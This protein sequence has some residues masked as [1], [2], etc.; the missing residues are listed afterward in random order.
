MRFFLLERIYTSKPLS[1]LFFQYVKTISQMDIFLVFLGLM[2]G[3]LGTMIGA[4]GGF[5]LVPVLLL[6]SPE[7]PPAIVTSISLA[8]VATNASVGSIAYINSKRIDYKSAFLFSLATIP[9]SI[10]GVLVTHIIPKEQF[11]LLFG[12]ILILLS[13]FLFMRGGRKKHSQ[14][15][16]PSKQKNKIFAD[17]TDKDGNQYQFSYNL[18]LGMGLSV[19]IGFIAPILGIGGGIIHV[20]AMIEWL[21]FPV[22]IATATS[23]FILAIMSIVSVITHYLEGSYSDPQTLKMIFNIAL[24]I[25]PGAIIGARLS[26]KVN[27]ALI[28]K[29]LS[30]SLIIAGI[31]I[32]FSA[33]G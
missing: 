6:L 17:L 23:H 31:R 22:H 12:I 8:I 18:G 7:L 19:F 5:I 15:I 11:N 3:T 16:N 27:G 28:I 2:I 10:L 26:S 20:P 29:L 33:F 4:G 13:L 21:G 1:L 14:Q 25:V 9:G 30:I 24:G 32:I